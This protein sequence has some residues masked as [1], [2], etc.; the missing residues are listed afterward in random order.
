[1]VVNMGADISIRINRAARLQSLMTPSHLRPP[2]CSAN[3]HTPHTHTHRLTPETK[4]CS[5]WF[6]LF[7]SRSLFSALHIDISA[8]LEG[9]PSICSLHCIQNNLE[10]KWMD[11]QPENIT[12][13]KPVAEAAEIQQNSIFRGCNQSSSW[14]LVLNNTQ[15]II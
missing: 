5:V 12:P 14:Y 2:Q 1:M 3:K 11:G 7:V 9:I 15:I 4:Q 10:A 6:E 8:K 13:A